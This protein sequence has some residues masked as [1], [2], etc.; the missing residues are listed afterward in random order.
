MSAFPTPH[1]FDEAE[2]AR[3]RSTSRR[4]AWAIGLAAALIYLGGFFLQ[5]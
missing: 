5:H 1:T 4:M 2:L 3:R